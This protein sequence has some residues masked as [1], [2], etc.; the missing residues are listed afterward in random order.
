MTRELSLTIIVPCLNEEANIDELVRR[1]LHALA[2]QGV[3]AE[4]LLVD[5]GSRDGTRAAIAAAARAH[6]QVRGLFHDENRGIAEAWR[7]G[8]AAARGSIVC[9]TDADLQYS[10]DDIPR[11]YQQLL[12]GAADVVQGWR[13][14]RDY[15]DQ[16]RY[17]LSV[18]FSALL[19]VLLGTR[20]RDVK[21]GFLCARRETFRAMLATRFRYRYFQHFLVVN[22]VSKGFRVHQESVTFRRRAG[23]ESFIASP[24][25]FAVAAL[26][27][28]PRAFWEFRVLNRRRRTSRCAG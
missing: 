17:G 18:A 10:P 25:R 12:K 21:S 6:P 3:D 2:A 20:L 1:T 28:L 15:P 16:Y 8:L 7:T 4:L 14:G 23:G 13:S 22:G 19:N 24:L 26:A 11:L 9:I 5:D 27:D